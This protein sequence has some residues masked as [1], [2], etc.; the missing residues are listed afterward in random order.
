M[1]AL[2]GPHPVSAKLQVRV[3]IELARAL[4]LEEGTRFYWRLSDDDPGV[5]T[6]LPEEVVER[7][8]SVG[9]R[10]E[11]LAR[12]RGGE[13]EGADDGAAAEVEDDETS[14]DRR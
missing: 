13:L 9:E 12:D 1:A 7:R 14:P 8:Y 6:L 5:L 10:L 2:H 4:R 3:P 11:A